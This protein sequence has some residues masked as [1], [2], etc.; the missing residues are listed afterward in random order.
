MYDRE[1]VDPRMKGKTYA[2]FCILYPQHFSTLFYK[3][4]A[5]TKIF[6]NKIKKLTDLADLT[7]EFLV[8]L[9]QEVYFKI[10][11]VFSPTSIFD[12]SLKVP[13]NFNQLEN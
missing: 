1:Q 12:T 6:Q 5:I 2:L 11:E 4:D 10:A 8:E 13:S 7:E 9:R 3:R